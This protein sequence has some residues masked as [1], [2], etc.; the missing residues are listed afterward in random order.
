MQGFLLKTVFAISYPALIFG[1]LY[2]NTFE[3]IHFNAYCRQE[4]FPQGGFCSEADE[5]VFKDFNTFVLYCFISFVWFLVST[6]VF[7]S[8]PHLRVW[9]RDKQYL[10]I[11]K[12]GVLL[13]IALLI[14]TIG[15]GILILQK[16]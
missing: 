2:E 12:F 4:I 1:V 5:A 3:A 16:G 14:L 10:N 13:S 8:G 7:R 11:G 6:L 9:V 15:T